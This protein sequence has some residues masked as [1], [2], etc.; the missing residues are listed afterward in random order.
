[1]TLFTYFAY[2]SNL[3]LE[4]LQARCPSAKHIENARAPNFTLAFTKR[5]RDGSAKAT[6]L[7]RREN[8]PEL[9]GALFEINLGERARLDVVEAGYDRD[10]TFTVRLLGSGKIRR[11]SV[12]AATVDAFTDNLAPYDWYRQLIISG[13]VQIEL[14]SHYVRHI[15][16]FEDMADPMPMRAGRTEAL[17]AL[18]MANL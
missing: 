14:P 2:G 15:E 4:R 16:G 9:L 18:K 11:V 17:A 5:S 13:A 6:Y 1:M 3:L 12:Y 10:D 7:P 8:E